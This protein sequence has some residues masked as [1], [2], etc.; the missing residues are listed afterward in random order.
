MDRRRE[1]GI[2]LLVVGG[3][4]VLTAISSFHSKL[5]VGISSEERSVSGREVELVDGVDVGLEAIGLVSR[6]E[7]DGD[8]S[9][10]HVEAI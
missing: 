3:D 10:R 6:V 9:G 5:H 1:E 7:V 4:F 2:I 8:A